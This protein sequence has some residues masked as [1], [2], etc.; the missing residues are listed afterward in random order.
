MIEDRGIDNFETINETSESDL[1]GSILLAQADPVPSPT[2][3]SASS[4]PP[5]G[6]APGISVIIPDADNK[7]TLAANASIEDIQ[8]DGDDPVSYTHLRAHET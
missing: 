1:G 2:E 3:T 8:L 5:S 4:T 7:V 6:G